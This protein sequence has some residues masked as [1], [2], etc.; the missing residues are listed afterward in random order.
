MALLI[1][2]LLILLFIRPPLQDVMMLQHLCLGKL[3]MQ[4]I[5]C[6]CGSQA[7]PHALSAL[8]PMPGSIQWPQPPQQLISS[9]DQM[10]VLVKAECTERESCILWYVRPRKCLLSL[11]HLCILR[12]LRQRQ[13]LQLLYL[14]CIFDGPTINGILRKFISS[15]ANKDEPAAA[16]PTTSP[17]PV[18]SAAFQQV[19]WA[20]ASK[21][22]RTREALNACPFQGNACIWS[23]PS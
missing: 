21:A 5:G 17:A 15:K 20:R 8:R 6:R 18:S 19:R 7:V 16:P 12:R 14:F 22:S 1:L 9:F 10:P 3:D 11:L 23:R 13:M 4:Q 2:A